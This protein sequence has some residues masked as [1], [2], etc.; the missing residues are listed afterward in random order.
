MS[1]ITDKERLDFMDDSRNQHETFL[2]HNY[3]AKFAG[4]MYAKA[5]R[6]SIGCVP[7]NA[8]SVAGFIYSD[9]RSAIDAGIELHRMALDYAPVAPEAA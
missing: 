5:I 6:G 4:M 9:I 3:G 8:G 7:T 2:V 1:H